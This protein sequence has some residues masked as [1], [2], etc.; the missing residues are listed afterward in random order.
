MNENVRLSF[1]L[2]QNE[3]ML[4]TTL[5][6][7]LDPELSPEDREG[8]Y[9]FKAELEAAILIQLD[10]PIMHIRSSIALFLS[11]AYM[12]AEIIILTLLA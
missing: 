2:E 4:A 12:L 8:C 1:P 9:E 7:L 6:I 3:R 10:E 11:N 5:D